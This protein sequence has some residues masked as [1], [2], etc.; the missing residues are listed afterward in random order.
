[1]ICGNPAAVGS[2]GG[3]GS[4][5][6]GGWDGVE[7]GSSNYIGAVSVPGGIRVT[8]GYPAVNPHAV[9]HFQLYRGTSNSFS[10]A[11]LRAVRATDEFTDFISEGEEQRYY[12]W[13]RLV[14]LSGAVHDPVGPGSAVYVPEG[15]AE[16]SAV[17]ISN[18]SQH[19]QDML[20]MIDP[21]QS[22]L[23]M[24]TLQREQIMELLSG[25]LADL[26]GSMN[27]RFDSVEEAV[28]EAVSLH[29]EFTAMANDLVAQV[30]QQ[31][32]DMLDEMAR[33]KAELEQSMEALQQA[34][35][36]TLDS[37]SLGLIV[38][39]DTGPDLSECE[40]LASF[41]RMACIVRKRAEWSSQ[42]T[43][44]QIVQ[45]QGTVDS[46]TKIVTLTQSEYD[47]LSSIDSNT[48]YVIRG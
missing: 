20:G 8:W 34:Q 5:G 45:V 12:Y 44:N 41:G 10:S 40:G 7:P 14:S 48:L 1:M 4:T 21:L 36:E 13:I 6:G 24:E 47:N 15:T 16:P 39:G 2:T 18:L 3:S 38:P 31:K 27:T 9:A 11:S 35:T 43:E 23:Q 25:S 37:F 28:D 33:I 29:E 26:E 17:E 42:R 32:Q 22:S 30:E 46:S 19:L